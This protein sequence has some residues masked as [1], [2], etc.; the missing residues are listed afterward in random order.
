M[1]TTAEVVLIK[2]HNPVE[3]A[4]RSISFGKRELQ[5]P[6]NHVSAIR[7]NPQTLSTNSTRQSETC[8]RLI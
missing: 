6:K 7:E 4:L 3:H 5:L 1:P 8:G 2:D